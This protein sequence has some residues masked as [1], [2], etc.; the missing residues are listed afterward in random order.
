MGEKTFGT[1]ISRIIVEANDELKTYRIK[2]ILRFPRELRAH[3]KHEIYISAEE[4]KKVCWAISEAEKKGYMSQE[5][6]ERL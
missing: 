3:S 4:L 5:E 6:Y 1:V 2:Q